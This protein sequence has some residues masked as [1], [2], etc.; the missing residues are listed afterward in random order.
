V[1]IAVYALLVVMCV[2]AI[3]SV[4]IWCCASGY[5][6][7]CLGLLE[8]LFMWLV[9]SICLALGN[10]N[11]DICQ[12]FDAELSS[13]QNGQKNSDVLS[14]LLGQFGA[15]CSAFGEL[16]QQSINAFYN[17]SAQFC[18]QYASLCSSNSTF[19]L[20]NCQNCTQATNFNTL[21]QTTQ[22]ANIG[23]CPS[24]CHVGCIP[25]TQCSVGNVTIANCINNC[26]TQQEMN[27]AAQAVTLAG[28]REI[29]NGVIQEL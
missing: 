9:F 23:I 27:A 15:N 10:V 3:A 29:L 18:A 6:N 13:Y 2:I 8:I 14:S 25:N 28:Y 5:I 17:Y 19:S 21:V 20:K 7:F 26:I 11:T 1:F 22:I 4:F 24:N 16:E 12:V